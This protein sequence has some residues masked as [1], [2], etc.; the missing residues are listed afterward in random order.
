MSINETPKPSPQKIS[1]LEWGC[2][3]AVVLGCAAA[4][5]PNQAD[6][7]LWGHVLYGVDALRDG[8]AETTTY[9]YTAEGFR[10]INHEN[11]AE[12]VMALVAVNYGATGLLVMKCLFGITIIAALAWWGYRQRVPLPPLAIALVVV[13]VNMAF[14]WA[15]RPQMFSARIP[16]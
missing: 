15:C 3:I 12:L 11:I 16:M 6:P 13:A 1:L 2:L 14:W 5:S 9:S 10:W 4:M 8:L 7:D